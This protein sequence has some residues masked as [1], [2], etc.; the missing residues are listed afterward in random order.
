[1]NNSIWKLIDDLDAKEGITEII[2]NSPQNVF[3]ERAGKFIQLNVE[4]SKKDFVEFAKEVAEKNHKIF[5]KSNP[6]LANRNNS[7]SSRNTYNNH[8]KNRNHNCSN[9]TLKSPKRHHA[10]ARAQF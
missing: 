8:R 4:L 5:D 6:I 2:I 7:R 1:M 10:A 9:D 3:V